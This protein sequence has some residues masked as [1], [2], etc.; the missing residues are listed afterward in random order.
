MLRVSRLSDGCGSM[1]RSVS[2]DSRLKVQVVAESD[3]GPMIFIMSVY[4][5]RA[6]TSVSQTWP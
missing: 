3:G 6:A 4:L 5:W 1:H 2:A